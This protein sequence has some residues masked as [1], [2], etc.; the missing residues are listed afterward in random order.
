[1]RSGASLTRLKMVAGWSAVVLAVGCAT[2]KVETLKEYSGKDPLP[3]PTR[4][5]VHDFAVSPD[6]VS[7]NSGPLARLARAFAEVPRRSSS[8]SDGRS[9]RPCRRRW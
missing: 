2:A 1:M 4:V 5:L 8:R 3:R 6:E 9:P 7:L